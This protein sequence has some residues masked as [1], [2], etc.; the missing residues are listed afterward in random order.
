VLNVLLGIEKG[1]TLQTP[2]KPLKGTFFSKLFNTVSEFVKSKLVCSV[3]SD[4]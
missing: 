3:I 2:L 4:V 1:H